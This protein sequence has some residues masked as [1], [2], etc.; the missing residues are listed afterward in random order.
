[1][2]GEDAFRLKVPLYESDYQRIK[3][4]K[5]IDFDALAKKAKQYAEVRS[6]PLLRGNSS[7]NK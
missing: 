3:K 5:Q 2:Y 4:E 6:Y 1:M 7:N